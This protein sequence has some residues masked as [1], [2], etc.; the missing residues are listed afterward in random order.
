M[1]IIS[2]QFMRSGLIVLLILMTSGCSNSKIAGAYS[3]TYE[4]CTG[5]IVSTTK[6]RLVIHA[7]GGFILTDYKDK[8]ALI[9]STLSY[10][11]V[12]ST[13]GIKLYVL[14]DTVTNNSFCLFKKGKKLFFYNCNVG[15]KYRY[16]NPF[17]KE[18]PAGAGLVTNA[19]Q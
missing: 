18:H 5:G 8:F 2:N 1:K 19:I 14:N 4:I 9:D 6:Q 3:R 13:S 12:K 15:K 17:V 10:G 11:T 7:D 16:A